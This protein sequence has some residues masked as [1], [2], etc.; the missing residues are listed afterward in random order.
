MTVN[1]D[2]KS[3]GDR[4]ISDEQSWNTAFS[5]RTS[6]ESGRKITSDELWHA[7]KHFAASVSTDEG[8]EIDALTN[9]FEMQISQLVKVWKECRSMRVR[10]RIEMPGHR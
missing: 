5:I 2:Q 7:R 3:I 9:T 4:K 8:I 10:N 6:F 1:I